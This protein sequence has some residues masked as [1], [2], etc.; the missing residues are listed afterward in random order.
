M[1][2]D[3][4]VIFRAP[5]WNPSF[6][7]KFYLSLKTPDW[8]RVVSTMRYLNG[9]VEKGEFKFR[10]LTAMET[11]VEDISRNIRIMMEGFKKKKGGELAS[12]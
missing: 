12:V 3:P 8:H 6:P 2:S 10:V 11:K 9:R 7:A 1:N 4:R 5:S